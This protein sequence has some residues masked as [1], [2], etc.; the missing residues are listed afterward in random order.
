MAHIVDRYHSSILVI[1]LGFYQV[2]QIYGMLWTQ[3]ELPLDLAVEKAGFTYPS[4]HSA[5]VLSQYLLTNAHHS[6][7]LHQWL[8]LLS[9]STTLRGLNLVMRIEMTQLYFTN[10]I[11]H[12]FLSVVSTERLINITGSHATH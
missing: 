10:L 1:N 3:E 11:P 8:I 4:N 2:V 6:R 7:S 5:F 12:V 9:K